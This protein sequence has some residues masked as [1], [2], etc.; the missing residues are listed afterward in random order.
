MEGTWRKKG[1]SKNLDDSPLAM[2]QTV[3]L[4]K[5]CAQ[6]FTLW[7]EKHPEASVALARFLD[8][9]GLQEDVASSFTLSQTP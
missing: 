9:K 2:K 1:S 6:S 8:A 4:S 3:M 5:K 7:A